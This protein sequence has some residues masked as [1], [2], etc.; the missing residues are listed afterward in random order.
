M[1]ET[2]FSN[3]EVLHSSNEADEKECTVVDSIVLNIGEHSYESRFV[4]ADTRYDV[5]LGTPWHHDVEPKTNYKDSSIEIEGL[6]IFGKKVDES[7]SINNIS[8]SGFR[9]L[10]KKKGTKVFAVCLNS[11]ETEED[12]FG[13]STEDPE[14]QEIIREYADV[15][16]S[17]LPPGLPP[18]RS[19]DHEILTDPD[20]KIPHRR[21]FRLSPDELRA[22]REYISENLANGRIRS[23]KSPY[24][25]PLFF[26]KQ[27]GKPLRAVVDYRL[28]NKITKKNNTPT[29]RSDEMFDI[30][31]CSRFFTKIDLKT[32]FHQIRVKP[33]DVEKTAFQTKYGQYEY[34]VLPMGLCNAPATFTTMMN[35]VLNG[36]VDKICTVYLDDILI[37]SSSR[38]EHIVH[39]KEVLERL[40]QHKLYASPK[41]CFFMT[42]EVE[43]LG[44]I[45]TDKGLKVNPEKT[46]II[47]KW[48]KPSTIT[49]VRSFLGLASF[50]RRFIKDFA[51]IALPLT[52][53]TKKGSTIQDWN[54]N[55]SISMEKLKQSL[56]SAPILSR[57]NYSEPYRCHVDA[58]QYAIGGTLTQ[59]IDGYFV[60]LQKT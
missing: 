46:D 16:K 29:P 47:R 54:E 7:C 18:K 13:S 58:S 11:L 56:T 57:P 27:E 49:E 2:N 17:K 55:C 23:S 31:G 42:Q 51:K 33:A 8:V 36:L 44:I 43:F 24:G 41:K 4:V 48:P 10:M 19:V 26:A 20:S 38:E 45:V 32:G 14:L 53:L 21:L 22:T 59:I 6:K 5:I 37:F 12:K 25:A 28:L 50:F 60:F 52:N 9:K 30:L 40:R 15:F 35:E 3:I 1:F 39:V 34:L